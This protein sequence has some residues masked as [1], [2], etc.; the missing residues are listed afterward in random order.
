MEESAIYRGETSSTVLAPPKVRSINSS[1]FSNKHCYEKK[2]SIARLQVSM[3]RNTGARVF[4]FCHKGVFIWRCRFAVKRRWHTFK[5]I[6]KYNATLR[7]GWWRNADKRLWVVWP[8]IKWA[9]P[10][11]RRK[12]KRLNSTQN[13]MCFLSLYNLGLRV[14]IT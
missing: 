12:K 4:D 10:F 14:T 7:G 9:R 6:K 11:K 3:H 8:F 5:I 1:T 2:N 13:Q